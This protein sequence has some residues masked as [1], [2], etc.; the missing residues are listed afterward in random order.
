MTRDVLARK[1]RRLCSYLTHLAHHAGRSGDDIADDPFEVERL[2][3]LV[4]QV[5]VDILSH[6]L[7]AR[8]IVPESYRDTFVQADVRACCP[9]PSPTPWRC[10]PD[11]ATCWSTPMKRSTTNW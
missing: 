7:A 9:N 3:E 8:G 6:E 2:L 1:L 11:S 10:Q 5:P 4:V